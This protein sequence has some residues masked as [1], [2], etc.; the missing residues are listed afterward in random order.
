V[1]GYVADVAVQDNAHVRA[2]DVIA[3]NATGET[4]GVQTQIS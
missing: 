1:S 4:L 3:R 2:G